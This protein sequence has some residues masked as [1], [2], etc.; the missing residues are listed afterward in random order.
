MKKLIVALA[1]LLIAA[2]VL[3]AIEGEGKL[4]AS[5]FSDPAMPVYKITNDFSERTEFTISV[6]YKPEVFDIKTIPQLPYKITLNSGESADLRLFIKPCCCGDPGDYAITI[7]ATS[8]KGDFV[9]KVNFVVQEAGKV[10]VSIEPTETQLGQC[11]ERT[12]IV[13]V[14]NASPAITNLVLSLNTDSPQLF[15]LSA[16]EMRLE[17]NSKKTVNL[18]IK[19]PCQFT[20]TK[21][22]V[23][24]VAKT[25][26]G[27]CP[28][29]AG[30]ASLTAG[31]V[32]RQNIE[33]EKKSFDVCN[34]IEQTTAIRI[35]NL[36]PRKDELSLSL[37]GP[38]WVVLQQKTLSIEGGKEGEV[39][40]KFLK[41]AFEGKFSFTLKAYS[42][43][44]DKNTAQQFEIMLRDCY[45]VD[46]EKF[47][48][49]ERACIEDKTLEY[50]FELKNT[51]N[52]EITFDLAL[53]GMKGTL[54]TTKLTLKPGESKEVK[55][56]ID[57]SAE[58]EG[59]KSFTI[60]ISSP[61]FSDSFKVNFELE[62]CYALSVDAKAIDKEI[63]M[64]VSPEL[65]PQ[66]VLLELKVTNMGT[67]EQ[68]VKLSLTGT[69]WVYLE[70]TSLKLAPKE[71]K[72]FYIYVGPPITETAGSYT[73]T[74]WVEATDYK[75]E[76]PIRI[77]LASVTLP[78][79]IGIETSAQVEETI[80][81]QEKTIKAKVRIV[82]TS[83][84]LLEVSD[85]KAEKYSVTFSP[86]KFTLD[87]NG[88]VELTATVAL[89]K[90]DV[91][92]LEVPIT[93]TTDRGIIKKSVVIDLVK[94]EVSEVPV[95]VTPTAKETATATKPVDQ[96]AAESPAA[97]VGQ[98][99][100]E[101]MTN[102]IVLLFLAVVAIVIV[103]L[104]YYA[105]KK[106]K[107][108]ETGFKNEKKSK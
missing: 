98:A 99:V 90:L 45:K 37:E 44:Y 63:K 58:R 10:K 57:V 27:D 4:T 20:P 16:K 86:T 19:A 93:V 97:P 88:F 51:K 35:K 42:K 36:G 1:F 55:A 106:E 66:S 71:T 85:V 61:Q 47:S 65:C 101:P 104:A 26:E 29:F 80:I 62:D 22:S 54:S 79:K 8:S 53:S 74:L 39:T 49:K 9:K 12:A 25:V 69:K 100:S 31:L 7:K 43:T 15:E 3:A 40:V 105:Y 83:D 87:K 6:D 107:S 50:S 17:A 34:D 52:T 73:A 92:S 84:C 103:I 14:E 72:P 75:K 30:S 77:N 89:G 76:F 64:E 56:T 91:N 67:K 82:N 60:S 68:D 70:P 78:Q 5:C 32:D 81:Q 48:G 2:S 11:D 95:K 24:V 108:E 13:T 38:D 28:K 33:I 23:E 18:K 21:K 59:K 102:I 46:I 41:N 94:K 96:N